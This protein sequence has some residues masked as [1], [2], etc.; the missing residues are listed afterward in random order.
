MPDLLAW[1]DPPDVSPYQGQVLFL[2]GGLSDY[3]TAQADAVISRLFPN[4][5]R[6]T[7]EGAS[8]WLHADKPAEVIAQLEGF[9]SE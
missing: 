2:R 1:R 3:V 9:F 6:A 7:V 5:R 4:A 8:H